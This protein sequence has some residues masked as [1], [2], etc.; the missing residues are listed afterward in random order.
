MVT[1]EK[2][3]VPD[4]IVSYNTKV[5][6]PGFEVVKSIRQI[7]HDNPETDVL[8]LQ[9]AQGYIDDLRRNFNGGWYLYAKSGW[10][11]SMQNPVMVRKKQGFPARDYTHGWG[12]VKNMRH[13]I[14]PKHGWDHP[15]RTWTWVKVGQLYVMSLHRA[16]DGDGQNKRAYIE[17]AERLEGFMERRGQKP[18]VIIGDTNTGLHAQHPGSM[19]KIK[20]HVRGK[21]IA[22]ADDP[23]IDY[24][25]TSKGVEGIVHRTQHYGSDHQ[26]AVMRRIRVT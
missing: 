18:V 14:G 12:V 17:E 25:L 11:E 19:Q 8:C 23:G 13:W 1:H 26:A 2:L 3:P 21:L 15:G 9:E 24:A 5:A 20:E 10:T 16:T 7:L 22:D 4:T 6:R